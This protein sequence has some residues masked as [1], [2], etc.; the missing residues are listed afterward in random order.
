[1]N[2]C[3]RL[4]RSGSLHFMKEQPGNY[5]TRSAEG[6]LKKDGTQSADDPFDFVLSDETADRHGDI[7]RA[8]GWNL[9][10]FKKNPIALYGHKHDATHVIG[11][12]SN[13][14]IEG[15]R[16][17]GRLKLAQAG[18]SEIVDIVRSLV[19]Q[20]IL[21]TVSVGLSILEYTPI[22]KNEPWGGWDITRAA[23]NE[24]SMVAVPANPNAMAL[25]KSA[26][27]PETVRIL[28]AQSG[29]D[30][31]D[32]PPVN[33][34]QSTHTIETPRLDAWRKRAKALGIN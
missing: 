6:P 29:H 34:G 7:I 18:T 17:L 12:W 20:R 27:S 13:V 21:K 15:K 9:S 22:D 25:A 30:T 3:P 31:G 4:F 32:E 28:F 19:E 5:R 16:L 11:N 26:Y 1:M 33:L 14:R 23:L 8:A 24:C 10:E 2:C